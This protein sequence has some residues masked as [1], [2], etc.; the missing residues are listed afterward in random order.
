MAATN[1]TATVTISVPLESYIDI[2]LKVYPGTGVEH[3]F[4]YDIHMIDDGYNFK[5]TDADP[6]NPLH[7]ILHLDHT[8]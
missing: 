1:E 3:S 4:P 2:S 8:V 6:L 5:G 7:P